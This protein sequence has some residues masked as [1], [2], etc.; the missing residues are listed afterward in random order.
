M[1]NLGVEFSLLDE[2]LLSPWI[3][4]DVLLTCLSDAN[5]WLRIGCYFVTYADLAV[6]F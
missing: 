2:N 4:L 3:C 1:A 5:I 6:V